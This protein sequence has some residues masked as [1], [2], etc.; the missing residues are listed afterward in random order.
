MLDSSGDPRERVAR[1]TEMTQVFLEKAKRH[2]NVHEN[3]RQTI[4]FVQ[5]TASVVGN[6]LVVYPP[7]SLGCAGICAI[8]P[9]C[10]SRPRRGVTT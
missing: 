3:V 2:Q 10:S 5:A 7:V 8:L 9:V 1:M 6:M 4:T